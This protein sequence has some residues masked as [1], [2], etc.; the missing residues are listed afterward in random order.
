[1]PFT[2]NWYCYDKN[3]MTYLLLLANTADDYYLTCTTRVDNAIYE[4]SKNDDRFLKF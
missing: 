1:M 2:V 4:Q 3:T